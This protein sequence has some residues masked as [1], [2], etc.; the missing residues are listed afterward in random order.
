MLLDANL[1]GRGVTTAGDGQQQSDMYLPY[2]Q[3]EYSYDQHN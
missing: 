2:L 3:Q 1:A